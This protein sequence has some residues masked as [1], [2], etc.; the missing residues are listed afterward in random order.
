MFEISSQRIGPQ[1]QWSGSQLSLVSR[2]WVA[3]RTYRKPL[4]ASHRP[5]TIV[6]KVRT[7]LRPLHQVVAFLILGK[8]DDDLFSV[9]LGTAFVH[10]KS[11]GHLA[12]TAVAILEGF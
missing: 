3:D 12:H 7:I 5:L 1:I 6:R 2:D 10:K 11:L 4:E 9:A 8:D